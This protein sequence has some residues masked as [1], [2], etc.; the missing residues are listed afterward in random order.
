[1]TTSSGHTLWALMITASSQSENGSLMTSGFSWLHQRSR[2]LL[3]LRPR[4][5]PA[6]RLQLR[7]PYICAACPHRLA[8]TTQPCM[9]A[10][11]LAKRR[12]ADVRLP[13]AHDACD[14][15]QH[16]S[17]ARMLLPLCFAHTAACCVNMAHPAG[18]CSSDAG[19]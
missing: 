16:T 7:A 8:C 5:P 12:S 2:Q 6:I 19:A 10:C 9:H 1:M 18:Q 17:A 4:M 3:P 13:L 15:S 11:L 14:L